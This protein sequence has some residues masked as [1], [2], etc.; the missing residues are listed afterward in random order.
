MSKEHPTRHMF[1]WVLETGDD[2]RRAVVVAPSRDL[3]RV[4]ATIEDPPGGW[5]DAAAHKLSPCRP[6]MTPRAIAIEGKS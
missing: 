5:R 3:A 1:I 6:S 2:K 4:Q